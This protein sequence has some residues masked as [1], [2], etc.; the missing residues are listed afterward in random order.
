MDTWCN[1][2]TK[3]QKR[4]IFLHL[5][6]LSDIIRITEGTPLFGRLTHNICILLLVY[7]IFLI[8]ASEKNWKFESP[9][10]KVP[11]PPKKNPSFDESPNQ[12]MHCLLMPTHKPN[13]RKE[14]ALRKHAALWSVI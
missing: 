14:K 5:S 8:S 7:A 3:L 6:P 1:K 13:R 12:K 2:I 4:V 9:N 11:P 10:G